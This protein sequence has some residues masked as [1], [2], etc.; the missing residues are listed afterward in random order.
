MK[1]KA[2]ILFDGDLCPAYCPQEVRGKLQYVYT[3]AVKA[4]LAQFFDLY[5]TAVER[6]TMNEHREALARAE[7]L[8]STWPMSKLTE[9][10]IA[11]YLPNAQILFYAAGSIQ[12]FGAP[13]LKRGIRMVS[14]WAAS[15]VPVMEYTFSLIQLGLKG[16]LP[17]QRITKADWGAGRR[18]ACHYPGAYRGVKV[19]VIG[20]GMIGKGVLRRLDALDIQKA[21]FDPYCARE[22]LDM[23]HAEA[24]T[25]LQAMFRD[26]QAVANLLPDLPSTRGMLRYEHFMAMPPYAT[27]INTGRNSEVDVSGLVRALKE[28]PDLMAVLDVIDPTEPPS[29]DHP[30]LACDNLFL[31]PHIAG[32]MGL[33]LE[34][35][36]EI[37]VDECRR[38]VQGAPLRYEVSDEMLRTMA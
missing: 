13:F 10:E 12:Y 31:T 7:V 28:R 3:D 29:P 27:F 15:G 2:V 34:R 14:A 37:I 6:G 1:Q 19:G 4:Q 18:L 20:A 25:D 22:M 38:Y 30:L 24:Y 11:A 26:C 32:S 8:F 33:E 5:P 23:L 21:A 17:I 9:A 35:Q 16:M 36:G